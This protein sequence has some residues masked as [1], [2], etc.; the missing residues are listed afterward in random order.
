M[1]HAV[2]PVRNWA[3]REGSWTNVDGY[4]SRFRKALRV[5]GDV[6]DGFDALLAVAEAAGVKAPA[7]SVRDARKKLKQESAESGGNVSDGI[8]EFPGKQTGFRH[9]GGVL[10]T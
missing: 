5:S 4:V 10:E 2:V 3:Q 8:F 6:L 9:V 1:A 7:K